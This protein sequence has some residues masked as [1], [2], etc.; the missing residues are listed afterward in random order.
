MSDTTDTTQPTEGA[1]QTVTVRFP[2]VPGFDLLVPDGTAMPE[3]VDAL[4]KMLATAAHRGWN[5]AEQWKAM[6]EDLKAEREGL[7]TKG[8]NEQE[9]DPAHD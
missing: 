2:D 1:P 3:L 6:A 7:T 8:I 5:E 4:A 9:P